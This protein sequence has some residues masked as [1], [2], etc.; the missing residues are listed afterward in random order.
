MRDQIV[1]QLKILKQLILQDEYDVDNEYYD[2]AYLFILLFSII[3]I[4]TKTKEFNI[5]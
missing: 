5:V 3:S 1:K 2:I 4:F